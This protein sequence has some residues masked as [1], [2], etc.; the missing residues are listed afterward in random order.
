MLNGKR[1]LH[2][3]VLYLVIGK[4]KFPWRFRVRRGK[5]HPSPGQLL[6]KLLAPVPKSLAQ[7]RTVIVQGDIEF[8]TVQ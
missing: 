2:L 1:G 3:V 7:G 4:R 6:C 5:G 8:G